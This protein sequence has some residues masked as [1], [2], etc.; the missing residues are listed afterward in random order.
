MSGSIV[1]KIK[2]EK[3]IIRKHPWIFSGA[4]SKAEGITKNGETVDIISHEGKLLGY[5]AF[6]EKSQIQVRVW[7]FNPEDKINS[8]FFY[9]KISKAIALRT[10]LGINKITDAYRIIY[11]ES[12]GLPGVIIDKYGDYLVCQFLSAGAEFWKTEI[13]D[14]LV[15]VFNPKGIYER[16]NVEARNKEGLE[17]VTGLT[18][19]EMPPALLEIKENN[20]KFFIDIQNGHKTGFYLDQREN[21]ILLSQLAE[22]KTVLNCFA[23]TGGFGVAALAG[24]AKHVVNIETSAD[25]LT[26][27]QKNFLLNNFSD[28]QFENIN[29]DVFK[30]LR[31]FRDSNKQFDIIILDPPK[32]AESVSQV[33][34]ASRGYK[35]INLLALKLI[36]PGGLLFTFSCSGHIGS[37]LFQKIV[38]D[39]ALDARRTVHISRRL[40]QS[41]DHPVAMNFP[42]AL[43]LKGLLLKLV[44]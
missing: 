7:S 4:V 19:G 32:F 34:K 15:S 8:E 39:A 23:Y 13:I 35:D 24:G 27:A 3:S 37:D 2:R 18:Y 17:L 9:T 29:E 1:L 14:N 41:A 12:D 38:A 42:E 33:E 22:N 25:A 44:D 21:R 16:S 28:R 43:Y 36:K 6:S 5:G 40:T 31:K 30:V 10:E 20:Y 26:L 11:S